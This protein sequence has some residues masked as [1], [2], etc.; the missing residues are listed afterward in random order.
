MKQ[1]VSH[2]VKVVI[3]L[4]VCIMVPNTWAEATADSTTWEGSY[5]AECAAAICGWLDRL[6]R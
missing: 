4:L 3:C 5:E 2:I 1:G 6:C